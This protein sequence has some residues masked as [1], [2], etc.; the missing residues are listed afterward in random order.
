MLEVQE[1][2]AAQGYDDVPIVR[3]SA[4]R[5]LHAIEDGQADD[6]AC[7]CI[8]QLVEALDWFI[9][10]PERDFESPFLMPIE[11]V[12]TI[13]GPRHG[14]DRSRAAR[15]ARRRRRRSRSSGSS[16]AIARARSW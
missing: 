15:R 1:L 12:L 10:D 11:D 14:R 7:D 5:A 3:G 16:T 4:L 13:P 2:L 6:P 9:P 8:V